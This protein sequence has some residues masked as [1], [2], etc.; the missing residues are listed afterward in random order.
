MLIPVQTISYCKQQPGRGSPQGH[1]RVKAVL[2][3]KIRSG[4]QAAPPSPPKPVMPTPKE[5]N[6]KPRSWKLEP[7]DLFKDLKVEVTIE[8]GTSALED[9][10]ESKA[11]DGNTP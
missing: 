7:L 8:L 5:R 10:A 1:W 3:D 4:Q 11:I 9:L 6:C 2:G